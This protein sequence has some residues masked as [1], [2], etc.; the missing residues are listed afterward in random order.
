MPKRKS[1]SVIQRLACLAGKQCD[2][3]SNPV[4]AKDNKFLQGPK[5]NSNTLSIQNEVWWQ[6]V[7]LRWWN[8]LLIREILGHLTNMA[9]KSSQSIIWLPKVKLLGLSRLF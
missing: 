9:Q 3:G 5:K 6:S 8:G 4:L 2:T 1:V 7:W